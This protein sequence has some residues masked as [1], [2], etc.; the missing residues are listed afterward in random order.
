A[1]KEK[2]SKLIK[3]TAT[4]TKTKEKVEAQPDSDIFDVRI[5]TLF[6]CAAHIE[7]FKSTVTEGVYAVVLSK[8]NQFTLAKMLLEHCK[9]LSSESIKKWLEDY[10]AQMM[11]PKKE[12][13]KESSEYYKWQEKLI[14][15]WENIIRDVSK[16]EVAVEGF[17]SVVKECHSDEPL[18]LP[19][20]IASTLKNLNKA[21][22][23]LE[24]LQEVP[25]PAT[26][27]R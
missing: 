7:A 18:Q 21:L 17:E 12:P 27:E 5:T 16:F 1:S 4:I 11:N 6:S 14:Q 19:R 13:K 24:R 22:Q 9:S 3:S 2:T 8:E 20:N 15:T 23:R 10:Y 25:A 26:Q